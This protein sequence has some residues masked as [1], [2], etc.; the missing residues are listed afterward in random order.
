[1]AQMMAETMD[2]TMVANWVA[3]LGSWMV[4]QMER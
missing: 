3:M 4:A 2:E 1:M